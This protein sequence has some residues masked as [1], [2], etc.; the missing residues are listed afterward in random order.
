MVLLY[1]FS[2][3]IRKACFGPPP[4]YLCPVTGV[5]YLPVGDAIAYSLPVIL[6][7]VISIGTYV[8]MRWQ[9]QKGFVASKGA[10]ISKVYSKD[11]E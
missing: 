3:V 9:Y 7:L 4:N 2:T 6:G 8:E 10:F 1:L 5:A 11:I